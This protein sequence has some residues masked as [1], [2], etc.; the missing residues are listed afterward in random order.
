MMIDS[1]ACLWHLHARDTTLVAISRAPL[2]KLEAYRER[3]GWTVP[4]V[5]S[6]GS[7]FNYDFNATIDKDIAPEPLHNFEPWPQRRPPSCPGCAATTSTRATREKATRR[8]TAP[9]TTARAH[10]AGHRARGRTHS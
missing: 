6:Y 7:D 4:W 2:A 8:R 10:A 9:A 3:M 5:S 1:I